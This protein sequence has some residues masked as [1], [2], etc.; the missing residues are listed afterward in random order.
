MS[1]ISFP[2]FFL[3]VISVAIG[4]DADPNELEKVTT[5]RK[6]SIKS[7]KREEAKALGKKIVKIIVKGNEKLVR[8]SNY[9]SNKDTLTLFAMAKSHF[10]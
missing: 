8:T 10:S 5:N 3:K 1:Q 4:T 9:L 2:I 6:N 7:P